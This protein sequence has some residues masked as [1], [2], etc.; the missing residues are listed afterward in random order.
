MLLWLITAVNAAFLGIDFGQQSIKA[1]V[2]SPK[3]M[4]DI[5]L[6]PEAKRKDTSGINIRKVGKVLERHYGNAIGSLAT[7]FPQNTAMHL[8]ALLG[9]SIDD[10]D[11]VAHYLSEFPGLNI[12]KTERNTLAITLDGTEYPVEQLV[13]MNLE[14]IIGRANAHIKE[15]DPHEI[16][17][18]EQIAIAVPDHFNQEQRRALLDSI[19]LTS[20]RQDAILVSD[21][22]SVAIDYALKKPEL[23]IN[24]PQYFIVY[25]LGSSGIKATLFSLMQPDDA[26]SPIR[27]EIGAFAYEEGISGSQFVT[28]IADIVEEKFLESNSKVNAK[29]FRDNARTRAKIIQA[30]EK[31]KLVLSANNEAFISIES[32]FDDIDFKSKVS[33]SEFQESFESKKSH[34]SKPVQDLVM[35]QLWEDNISIEDVTGIL[36][37]GG[38][39]RVPMIQE[40][41]ANQLGE[42]KIL[43]N[44]NADESVIN[45]ATL[46][47]LKYFGSF[48]TKPL[49]IIERSIYD[50][51]A[52]MLGEKSNQIIFEQGSTYPNV[53]SIASKLPK[54]IPNALTYDLFEDGKSVGSIE[55]DV[56]SVNGNWSSICK[57]GDLIAN[58]TFS[59]TESRVF[60]IKSLDIYCDLE[61]KGNVENFELLDSLTDKN[62]TDSIQPLSIK[63]KKY[64]KRRI[65]DLNN[66]DKER[67]KVQE[68]L[69]TLEAELYNARGYIEE[70]YEKLNDE[71]LLVLDDL[72]DY[73]KTTLELIE[74]SAFDINSKVLDDISREFNSKLIKAKKYIKALDEPL[75]SSEFKKL[76]KKASKVIEDSKSFEK[77]CQNDIEKRT[78]RFSKVGID[79]FKKYNETLVKYPQIESA[80]N[81]IN[82]TSVKIEDVLLTINEI[83]ESKTLEEQSVEALIKL[84]LDL[85]DYINTLEY[86]TNRWRYQHQQVLKDLKTAF[87]KKMKA[88]KKKEAEAKKVEEEEDDD[89]VDEDEDDEVV[90]TET[91][92]SAA[93][94]SRSNTD[95]STNENDIKT[96]GSAEDIIDDEL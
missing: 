38:S 80:M 10:E 74:E 1:M 86:T 93:D 39:S 36:L 8:R 94:E 20:G 13:G 26:T 73:T 92:K 62:I 43:R 66:K 51:S 82:S 78:E 88:I 72:A 91:A 81:V 41:L 18:V 34:I 63:Q 32:L 64:L 84:K 35:N 53:T 30:A 14:E 31:A 79:V 33:R 21:G 56:S 90:S 52:S 65:L 96:S 70:A 68:G 40:E 89:D 9:R 27:I 69:N 37:A 59:L 19:S 60:G 6:T 49:D 67:K 4:M 50:Y 55:F 45:G 83:L 54:K 95:S 15:A 58:A 42:E 11:V 71:T 3:A 7:R 57:K 46:R 77:Q 12:S 75:T 24:V 17:F 16:D 44:V 76:I 2:V 23:E 47:G 22:L 29:K 28:A 25:D 87:N 48:K 85:T 61:R 5:I